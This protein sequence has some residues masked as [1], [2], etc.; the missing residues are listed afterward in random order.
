MVT[1]VI[2]AC[3]RNLYL[4]V[5]WSEG[6]RLSLMMQGDHPNKH[7]LPRKLMDCMQD[8]PLQVFDV[9]NW[10]APKHRDSRQLMPL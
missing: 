8:K 7:N 5:Q 1:A 6:A 10:K 4:N 2:G 9:V 3:H